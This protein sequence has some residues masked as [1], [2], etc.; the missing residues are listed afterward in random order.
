MIERHR[1]QQFVKD[2]DQLVNQ[3]LPRSVSGP[4]KQWVKGKLVGPALDSLRELIL[5]NRPPVIFL[6]G[7]SGHGKSTLINALCGKNVAPVGHV[8]PTTYEAK[9]YHVLFREGR[10]SWDVVDTRGLFETTSPTGGPGEDVTEQLI[11]DM[12]QYKPDIILHVI[13]MLEVRG[14]SQDLAAMQKIMRRASAQAGRNIPII[15]ALSKADIIGNPREW[16]PETQPAK[17]GQIVEAVRYMAHEVLSIKPEQ[18][19]PLRFETPLYGYHSPGHA[20]HK[21]VI[22]LCA[23][24]E[25]PEVWNVDLLQEVVGEELPRESQ[26]DYYQALQRKDLLRKLAGKVTAR[27]AEISG[28][29]GAAPLPIADMAVLSP[30][31]VLLVVI[32][33][34][35]SCRPVVKAT[36]KEYALSVGLTG[37][38]GY[39]LRTAAQQLVKLI[40]IPGAGSTISAGIA[41][42]GT[43]AI[44]RSAERYFFGGEKLLPVVDEAASMGQ[45]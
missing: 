33:G 22:P 40:P 25:T 3:L 26:L 44:G 11:S 31:Q 39:L 4:T 6:I 23:L 19:T 24:W 27:F 2:L 30:L 43:L 34:G 21:A 28:A 37:G 41:Y 15:V 13:T 17:A 1:T 18:V 35:L 32:I 9:A 36:F 5:D 7:R 16:P 42:G 14:L 20:T 10:I 12:A 8:E 29:V 38:M 45:S